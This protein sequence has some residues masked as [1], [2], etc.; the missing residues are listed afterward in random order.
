[1]GV[2]ER[3]SGRFAMILEDQ[4]VLEAPVLLEVENAVAESPKYVFDPPGRQG[5]QGRV[6]IGRFDD[7][8]VGADA[9]HL[10]EHTLGLLVQ[11]AFDSESRKLVGHHAHRPAGTVLLSRGPVRARTIGQNLRRSFALIS[12]VERTKT[13][14]LDLHRF[15]HKVGGPLGAIGGNNDPPSYDGVFS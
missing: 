3:S 12:V 9:I 2:L 6:V 8:L 10:V 1:M 13:S 15:A 7:D 14:A 4:D 11:V 5:R